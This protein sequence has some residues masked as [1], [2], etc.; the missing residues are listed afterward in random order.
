MALPSAGCDLLF[1]LDEVKG[2]QHCPALKTS[3]SGEG[4]DINHRKINHRGLGIYLLPLFARVTG[5]LTLWGGFTFPL[6]EK[7]M[8]YIQNSRENNWR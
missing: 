6:S 4:S 1:R 8:V 5:N 2:I 7:A 3:P